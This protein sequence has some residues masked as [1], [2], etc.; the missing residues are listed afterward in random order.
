MLNL[1]LRQILNPDML[2]SVLGIVAAILTTSSFLPQMVKAY[3]TKSMHDVSRYLMS[4]FATGTV[5]WM[6]YGIY[7][8]DLVI[9]GANAIA[10]VFN[11]VLLYM[12]FS[13]GKKSTKMT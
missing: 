1:L 9:V 7:K 6:L 4:L 5:L 13:Y 2:V 12:K 10:T 11:V 8:S 3:R